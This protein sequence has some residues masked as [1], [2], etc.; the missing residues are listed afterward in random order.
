M[1][2]TRKTI[3]VFE[4]QCNYGFGNGWECVCTEGT[5]QEAKK[6]KRDYLVNMPQYPYR[7]VK[8]RERKE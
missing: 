1:K 7:I 5:W 2:Y 8:K 3:D 4:L 6:V